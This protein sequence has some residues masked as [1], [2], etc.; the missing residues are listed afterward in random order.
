MFLE[1]REPRR[2]AAILNG[3][4]ATIAPSPTRNPAAPPVSIYV[5]LM[6]VLLNMTAYRGSK[7]TVTLFAV[8]L[9]LPQF[10]IGAIVALYSVFPVLLGLYAGRLTDRLGVRTPMIAGTLGVSTALLVPFV[11]PNTPALFASAALLGATW[12]FYNICAQNLIGIL[13]DTE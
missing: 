13:R 1:V 7:V 3:C 10:Y 6:I 9:G 12:V 5:V 11:L 4:R 8:D 2:K